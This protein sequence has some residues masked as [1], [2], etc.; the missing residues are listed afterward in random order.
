VF[1]AHGFFSRKAHIIADFFSPAS[2]LRIFPG[3]LFVCV[4]SAPGFSAVALRQPDY[5]VLTPSFRDQ[6]TES[7]NSELPLF[8][9]PKTED[10]KQK[11]GNKME[12]R[13]RRQKPVVGARQNMSQT[14]ASKTGS[15][16]ERITS[17]PP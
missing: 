7:S 1:F 6:P 2:L 16:G 3:R 11:T 14:Q 12:A 17:R 10:R 5:R 4:V 13:R 15:V 9:A 8:D